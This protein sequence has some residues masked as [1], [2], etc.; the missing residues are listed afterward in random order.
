MCTLCPLQRDTVTSHRVAQLAGTVL[1]AGLLQ[2]AEP[3]ALA[4]LHDAVV[5]LAAQPL[6]AAGASYRSSWLSS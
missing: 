2:E 6:E 5:D 3:D 1:L 4:S